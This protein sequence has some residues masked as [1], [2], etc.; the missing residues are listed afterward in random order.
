MEKPILSSFPLLTTVDIQE[1]ER[2]LPTA[3]DENLSLLQKVNKVIA[4]LNQISV[5]TNGLLEK[6]NEVMEWMLS[7]GVEDSVVEKLV[8]WL[9]DGTLVEIINEDVF[10]MK[11]D[12]SDVEQLVAETKTVGV[13]GDFATI[14]EALA[15]YSMRKVIYQSNGLQ[16]EIKLKAGYIVKEQI[17][18]K[19]IDLGWITIT[20]ESPQVYVDRDSITTVVS[21]D[22]K[23][24]FSGSDN[25]VLPIIAVQFILSSGTNE[26]V[27]GV[28]VFRGSK[29]TLI[30]PAGFKGF[31]RGLGAYFN[32]EINYYR[33][34][35]S[36]DTYSGQLADFSGSLDS[37]FY[38]TFNSTIGVP[39]ANL[40]DATYHGAMGIWNSIVDVYRSR[41]RNCGGYGFY[42]RD[43]SRM[44]ARE[45][46]ASGCDVGYYALHKSTINARFKPDTGVSNS[47]G[48]SNCRI[49]VY[50][51]HNS[52]IDAEEMKA[53]DCTEF[54][55][56][57]GHTSSIE[58]RLGDFS[59]STT[60]AKAECN[61]RINARS[62]TAQYCTIGLEADEASTIS[63]TLSIL[64][65][66]SSNAAYAQYCSTIDMESAQALNC[67]SVAVLARDNSRINANSV[68]ATGAGVR[69]VNATEGSVINCKDANFRRGTVDNGSD[70][71][72]Y[73]GGQIIAVGATGGYNV[74]P[75]TV[76]TNGIVFN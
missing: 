11:A 3:F 47:M 15:Y 21:D 48:A 66:C 76:T 53:T 69:G 5:S 35:L 51:L 18:L 43:G 71:V 32:S 64:N 34:G 13:D 26:R 63:A 42:V 56:Y 74:V 49:G 61:S 36:L 8:E 72:V 23:P 75:F 58:C 39:Y 16:V 14:N 24:V 46:D 73:D 29:A 40:D 31:Y 30:E 12:T 33:N 38:A 37:G 65:N 50:A 70:M 68:V 2:Y 28:C 10:N 4:F 60:G 45:T 19:K 54:G 27:D 52:D 22:R 67:G 59:R 25:A 55:L 44:N 7:N 6:W 62:C 9:E 20:S 1:Y 17:I 41:A 57:A